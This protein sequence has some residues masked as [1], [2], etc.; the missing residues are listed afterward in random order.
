MS[1]QSPCRWQ[2]SQHS[3]PCTSSWTGSKIILVPTVSW[4]NNFFYQI[5]PQ[6]KGSQGFT[7]V[8]IMFLPS[9]AGAWMLQFVQLMAFRACCQAMSFLGVALW[10]RHSQLTAWVDCLWGQSCAGSDVNC[11][12]SLLS[13]LTDAGP[14]LP[15][16]S[17]SCLPS[18]QGFSMLQPRGIS[19]WATTAWLPTVILHPIVLPH[20]LF[21][22]L[23]SDCKPSRCHFVQ[24]NASP[25][26]NSWMSAEV[27]GLSD[28]C[29]LYSYDPL[30]WKEL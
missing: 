9:A 16:A 4:C 25:A 11:P 7:S 27:V 14:R 20:D 1:R 13:L 6:A 19:I 17:Q 29:S 22:H 12:H 2:L 8:E 26:A 5:S 3:E 10:G 15:F 30:G 24:W 21:R 23:C 18:L 28:V